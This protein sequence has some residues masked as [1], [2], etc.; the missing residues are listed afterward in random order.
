MW[1][2]HVSKAVSE[3][4][5]VFLSSAWVAGLQLLI[6]LVAVAIAINCDDE[7]DEDEDEAQG[8]G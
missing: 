1:Y 8:I 3:K 6:V 7:K 2:Q 4:V 5:R